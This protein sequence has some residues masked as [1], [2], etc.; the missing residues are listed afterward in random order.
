MRK[1]LLIVGQGPSRSHKSGIQALDGKGSGD[2]LAKLAGISRGELMA[3]AET[4]NVLEHY[5]GS[6]GKGD[7][8][9]ISVAKERAFEIQKSLWEYDRAVLLGQNVAK[10]FGLDFKVGQ[11]SWKMNGCEVS[12]IPHPSGVN[13]WYNKIENRELAGEVLREALGF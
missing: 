4:V 1:R 12:M 7:S 9:S 6:N 5:C 2:R 8:F 11:L 13:R 10:A 3:R